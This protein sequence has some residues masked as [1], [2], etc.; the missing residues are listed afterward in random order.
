MDIL[1]T[2]GAGFLGSH[3]LLNWLRHQPTSRVLCLVRGNRESSVTGR[4][5]RALEQ[6]AFECDLEIKL[7]QLVDR[8]TVVESDIDQPQWRDLPKVASW[9]KQTAGFEVVHG[10]ANLSFQEKDR[11]KV[12]HTNVTGTTS[13]L[14]ALQGLPGLVAFN[15]ISTAYVAGT[16]H[17][18]ILEDCLQRPPFFNNVY[19][20]S[21]WAAEEVVRKETQKMSV[22]ARIFRPSIVVGHSIT[23][24]IGAK[25]GFY[26]VVEILA[27]FG[28]HCKVSS[29][30]VEIPTKRNASL[31][32]IPIDLVVLEMMDVIAAGSLSFGR[33]FHLTNERPLS[34]A[35]IFYG[36]SPLTGVR[37]SCGPER[38]VPQAKSTAA[39]IFRGLRH[40]LPYFS[41]ARTF[42]RS[43][44]KLFGADRHQQQ[45]WLDMVTLREFVLAFIEA[46]AQKAALSHKTVE[47]QA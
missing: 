31:N 45:Y 47:S 42:D 40:Y 9:L 1:L 28:R 18:V 2:G 25:T 19:E 4:I 36:V 14:K 26:K 35:D 38:A 11:E 44:V 15:Y 13:L 22:G 24:R 10:A 46:E 41:Y 33:V 32:L 20:E 8:I 27:Q 34:V 7:D 30:V 3:L 39:L 6:A 43:N 16:K 21:K 23:L 29:G 37:L 5:E 17:G 12:W